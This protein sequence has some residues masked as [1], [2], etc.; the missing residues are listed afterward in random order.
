MSEAQIRLL[1]ASVLSAAL[2]GFG[3]YVLLDGQS[4]ADLQKVAAGWI[5]VVIGYWLK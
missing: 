5:G 4:S 1:G 2:V 3:F